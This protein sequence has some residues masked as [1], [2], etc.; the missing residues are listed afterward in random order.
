MSGRRTGLIM[1]G[2]A[3][4]GMFTCGV[5][6]VMME[7]GITFDGAIGVSAGAAFGCNFKSHQIGRPLRYN[8]DYCRDPRYGSFRSLLKT[9]D[10][11]DAEFCYKTLPRELDIF[12][13]ETFEKN[14]MEFYVV[15]TDVETGKPVYYRCS[16]GGERDITWLR[17][18]ATMPLVSKIVEADGYKLLDGGMGDSIPLKYFESIG[19]DHN[20]VILTQPK[21]FVKKPA[22]Y[23][24]MAYVLLRKYP[25]LLRTMTNRHKKYNATTA[26]IKKRK[27]QGDVFVI[28]PDEPLHI[29]PATHDPKELDRV[30][31]IGR[32]TALRELEAL[33]NFLA[34][35]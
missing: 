8:K 32:K 33:K 4:R 21:D 28:Q 13:T 19:Y 10:M 22:K 14:P 23:L 3:M 11:Y 29:G 6:D 20:V 7:Q 9:G 35:K 1:E 15:C 2:G 16:D 30:Y 25:N 27:A 34:E 24:P 31:E 18:S 12:D 5:M 26:Y 17:A